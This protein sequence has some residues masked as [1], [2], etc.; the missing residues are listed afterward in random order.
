MDDNLRTLVGDGDDDLSPLGR[1]LEQA[2]NRLGISKREAARRA[3]ISDTRWR[4]VV[5]GYEIVGARRVSALAGPLTI[6][7]MAIAVDMHPADALH[8][9]GK[10]VTPALVH[11]LITSATYP[12][13]DPLRPAAPD[14]IDLVIAQIERITALP[15]RAHQKWA[16]IGPLCQLVEQALGAPGDEGVA[17]GPAAV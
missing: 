6:T 2:R 11:A 5:R 3:R 12:I 1:L 8:A 10:N 15:I 13:D 4:Q 17:D 9:A 16:L 14:W 7:R